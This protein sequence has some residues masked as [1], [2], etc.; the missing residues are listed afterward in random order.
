M[1]EEGRVR[2]VVGDGRVG[3]R[4]EGEGDAGG[5]DAIHVGAAAEKV[6]E[7]LVAQLREGGR[8]FIPVGKK[9]EEQSVW[10]VSKVGGEVK[11][12]KLFG[13]FY[14]P[15]TDAPPNSE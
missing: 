6:H 15:L 7:E 13:V 12:E 8:M 9:Y 5:W 2:F 14:V 10:L 3:F 4:E 1:V 11:K